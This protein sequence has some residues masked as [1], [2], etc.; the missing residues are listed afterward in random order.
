[1]NSS[2]Q[3]T[4]DDVAQA[5][6]I[7]RRGDEMRS[8][9]DDAAITEM[10][11]R[12]S[13]LASALLEKQLP[14]EA[15]SVLA[16]LVAFSRAA[17]YRSKNYVPAWK[18]GDEFELHVRRHEGFLAALTN[19]AQEVFH[20]ARE[21]TDEGLRLVAQQVWDTLRQQLTD[22]PVAA[23]NAIFA[24]VL[25]SAH[26]ASSFAAQLNDSRRDLRTIPGSWEIVYTRFSPLQGGEDQFAE[27]FR[28]EEAVPVGKVSPLVDGLEAVERG[29]PK[30]HVLFFLDHPAS[31]VWGPDEAREAREWLAGTFLS[32]LPHFLRT[33][34]PI[35][36]E[37]TLA[38]QGR[39]AMEMP[40]S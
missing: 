32:A 20:E 26:L 17:I 2:S 5:R 16:R 19:T 30:L 33:A 25:A 12:A 34:W 27:M 1:M 10:L 29:R 31:A 11:K 22:D 36:L 38:E 9:V 21:S 13:L 28:G 14:E 35:R 24:D 3:L 40:G 18:T 7:Q 4:F 6:I 15:E 37:E 8:G 39:D 23:V